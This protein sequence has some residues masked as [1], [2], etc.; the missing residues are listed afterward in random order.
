MACHTYRSDTTCQT[1]V[2]GGSRSMRIITSYGSFYNHTQSLSVS[3]SVAD[4]VGE[5]SSEYDV[6]AIEIDYR[7]AINN[8]LPSSISLIGEE[9]IGPAC[10]YEGEFAGRTLLDNGRPDIGLIVASI[11][12]WSIVDRHE[13]LT[14]PELAA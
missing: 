10:P 7:D 4:I 8:T 13:Y 3:D 1:K 6:K 12:I 14:G 2:L 11:D 9:F 5:F